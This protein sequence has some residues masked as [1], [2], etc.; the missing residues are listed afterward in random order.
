MRTDLSGPDL[1]DVSVDRTSF[2][3]V[4]DE[5]TVLTGLSGT[6][7][8]PAGVRDATD[9]DPRELASTALEQ[10]LNARGASV[11]VLAPGES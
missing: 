10:W 9:G 11:R 1:S 6:V 3:V 5:R 4:L 2:K 7:Y 8:G